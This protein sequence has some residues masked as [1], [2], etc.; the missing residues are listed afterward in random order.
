VLLSN[1]ITAVLKTVW[2]DVGNIWAVCWN[3]LENSL[4]PIQLY[5]FGAFIVPSIL[6]WIY[7]IV[8]SYFDLQ[9]N[10]FLRSWKIQPDKNDPLERERLLECIKVALFNQF[11]ITPPVGLVFYYLYRWRGCSMTLPLPSFNSFVFQIAMCILVVETLFYYFHRLLHLPYVYRLYHK[12]HHTWT[13]P[14]AFAAVYCHP[15][16]HVVGNLLP[17]LCGPLF[18]NA[19]LAVTFVWI[20]MTLSNTCFVHSGYHLPFLPSSESHDWHHLRFN[21]N[22]G[23]IGLLDYFH[24]TDTAFRQSLQFQRHRVLCSLDDLQSQQKSS[25]KPIN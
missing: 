25:K 22:F 18:I 1:S 9:T 6:Y 10:S 2:C 17:I 16:E 5:V 7:G 23:A 19:H 3:Y 15:V 24:G 11:I 8:F 21:E 12:K 14:I 13:A 4:T 20:I